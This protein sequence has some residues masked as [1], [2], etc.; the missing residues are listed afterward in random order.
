MSYP[1]RQ[2]CESYTKEEEEEK[3]KKKKRA[4]VCRNASGEV[5]MCSWEVMQNGKRGRQVRK[6]AEL[7]LAPACVQGPLSHLI[8]EITSLRNQTIRP[9]TFL[10][11]D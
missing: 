10:G 5:R 8:S 3:V 7:D 1:K 9:L 4:K 11:G 6:V 2:N